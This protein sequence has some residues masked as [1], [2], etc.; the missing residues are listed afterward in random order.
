MF[1]PKFNHTL[2]QCSHEN[3]VTEVSIGAAKIFLVIIVFALA[4]ARRTMVKF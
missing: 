3:L 2:A 1:A 4:Y